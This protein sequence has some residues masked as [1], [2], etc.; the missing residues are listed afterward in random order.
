MPPMEMLL[1]MMIKPLLLCAI[2]FG[3]WSSQRQQS[4]AQHHRQGVWVMSA[5]PLVALTPWMP[6]V[7]WPVSSLPSSVFPALLSRQ[8]VLTVLFVYIAV[9]LMLVFYRLLSVWD[10][11]RWESRMTE[12]E[13]ALTVRANRLWSL[14]EAKG[15]PSCSIEAR[16][17]TNDVVHGAYTWGVQAGRR[18]VRLVIAQAMLS[19]PEEKLNLVLAHELGHVQRNDWLKS[20][21]LYVLCSV[22]W[23]LLPVWVAARRLND[24]AENACDDWV[25]KKLSSSDAEELCDIELPSEQGQAEYAELLL[26][27]KRQH[28]RAG[29]Q[30]SGLQR[31]EVQSLVGA[32]RHRSPFYLRLNRILLRYVD[33][34]EPSGKD[35]LPLA[36]ITLLW[37]IPVLIANVECVQHIEDQLSLASF[38]LLPLQLHEDKQ[39]DAKSLDKQ[40]EQQRPRLTWQAVPTNRQREGEPKGDWKRAIHW[41]EEIIVSA[42]KPITVPEQLGAE[43]WG[44]NETSLGKARIQLP[45]VTV[46]GYL[47]VSVITPI[48]P[49]GALRRGR[50]GKVI[51]QF[52][53]TESGKVN[54]P[55][56]IYSEPKR[57]FDAAVMAAIKQFRF[58]PQRVNGRP[59]WVENVTETF[60]FRLEASSAQSTLSDLRPPDT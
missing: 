3:V 55:N 42:Q 18:R 29:L 17:C 54:A 48:Y 20:Q 56:I 50:E 53:I 4:A 35:N 9:A 37:C 59:V 36:M 57:L 7:E 28:S 47:P 19:W 60:L 51:V 30:R 43:K 16:V 6:S 40:D 49:T 24:L 14:L 13:H 10:L 58:Q 41:D 46:E 1:L 5:L 27:L 52:D 45:Q 12:P 26:N 39:T 21:W 32:T 22:F 23:C 44:V 33:R 25:V 11:S 15:E 8:V 2:L 38:Q 34:D 31:S